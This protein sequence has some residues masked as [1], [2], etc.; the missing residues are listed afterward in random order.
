MSR[1]ARK[2]V[3]LRYYPGNV[4]AGTIWLPLGMRVTVRCV[5]RD[6]RLP[7]LDRTVSQRV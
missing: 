3:T 4:I 2:L 5:L 6:S 7:R 1:L